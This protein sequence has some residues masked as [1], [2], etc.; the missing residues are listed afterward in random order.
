MQINLIAIGKRMPEWVTT[1]YQEYAKRMPSDFKLQLFEISAQKR[2]KESGLL[3]ALQQE[4]EQMLTAIPKENLTIALDVKGKMWDTYQLAQ[5]LQKWHDQNIDIS[6]L[7]GGPE[8]L[9]L[10]CLK[11]AD[12]LWSLSPLTFPHPLVR[13]IVAEQLYRAWSILSHHPYHRH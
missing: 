9:T 3:K 13:I 4:E 8:G 7:I 5:L 6:L 10:N 1:G 2:S 11:R 12:L